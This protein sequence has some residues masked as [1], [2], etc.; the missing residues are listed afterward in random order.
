MFFTLFVQFTTQQ[1]T[2]PCLCLAARLGFMLADENRRD[3]RQ[4]TERQT[5][6][7][8]FLGSRS[9]GST[10]Q[11]CHRTPPREK[12]GASDATPDQGGKRETFL[13]MLHE[14][15]LLADVINAPGGKRSPPRDITLQNTKQYR[16]FVIEHLAKAS[17][18]NHEKSGHRISNNMVM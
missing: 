17:K 8:M 7:Y 13:K 5:L 1:L 3:N 14:G 11:L 9:L 15:K 10:G 6:E 12:L 18:N 4:Q 2:D 16:S